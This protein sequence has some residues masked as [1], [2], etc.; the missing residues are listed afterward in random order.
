MSRRAEV[1][2]TENGARC[3]SLT[4]AR[5]LRLHSS[6]D[7]MAIENINHFGFVL[8]KWVCYNAS[9]YC[10]TGPTAPNRRLEWQICVATALAAHTDPCAV[11][12]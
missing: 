7:A 4:I 3:G 5:H 11:T 8:P 2:L 9:N 12:V 10:N 6:L 1:V